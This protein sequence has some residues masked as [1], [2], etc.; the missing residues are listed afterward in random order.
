[1]KPK[2]RIHRLRGK[3]YNNSLITKCLKAAC[4]LLNFY[5]LQHGGFCL[6]G[7]YF[8]AAWWW[9]PTKDQLQLARLWVWA[10]RSRAWRRWPFPYS[11]MCI[12]RAGNC[13]FFT[14]Y[15]R[16]LHMSLPLIE[17]H[18]WFLSRIW[19]Q[20]GHNTI[21]TSSFVSKWRWPAFIEN[22]WLDYKLDDQ[23]KDNHIAQLTGM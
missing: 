19:L 13:C 10:T 17:L 2:T 7:F 14:E 23:L 12:Y 6:G 11:E 15:C 16:V 5:L 8:L 4:V 1:M 21:W 3:R 18:T 22:Q 20:V 9:M